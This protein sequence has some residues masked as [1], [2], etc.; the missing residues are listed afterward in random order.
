MT[1][2]DDKALGELFEALGA[3][4]EEAGTAVAIVVVGGSTLSY[5]G[6]VPRTTR[7]VDVIARAT[8]DGPRRLIP[9]R[10][11][12]PPFVEALERVARDYG[13]PADWLNTTVGAQWSFGLPE[14]FAE[15][16]EWRTFGA[17]EVGFAGRESLIALKLF[18]AVDQGA[19]SVHLQDL[20][21]LRPSAQELERAA[22]WVRTQDAGA[23]FP[24]LVEGVLDHV[25]RALG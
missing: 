16:L 10:P 8:T 24:S 17:L 7:D 21:A 12:P 9:A 2:L 20:L 6:W 18:A 22:A 25:R 5:R 13:L 11:L 19:G 23:D 4:L 15:E 3:H 14:G 1:H